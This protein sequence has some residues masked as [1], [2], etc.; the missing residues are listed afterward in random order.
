MGDR[1]EQYYGVSLI[2]EIPLEDVRS[3]AN[4]S[5]VKQW[6]ALAHRGD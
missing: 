2:D 6:E 3:A 1:G 4:A 5:L